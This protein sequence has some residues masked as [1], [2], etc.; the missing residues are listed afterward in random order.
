M[1][2]L[3]E[4]IEIVIRC[5]CDAKY[6]TLNLVYLYIKLLK[7]RFAPIGNETVNTYIN[8]IY[9]EKYEENDYDE[10]DDDIP[11]AGIRHYWQYAHRQ[12]CQKIRN[13]H[14]QK[15]K[16]RQNKD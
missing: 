7:K 8:L 10:I 13:I 2:K 16:Q 3:L 4:L 6:L 15:G 11:A 1:V 9:G 5:L 12:F 14:V